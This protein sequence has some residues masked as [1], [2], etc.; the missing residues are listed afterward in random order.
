MK[1]VYNFNAGPSALPLQVL[2]EGQREFLDYKNTGMSIVEMS[3]RSAAYQELHDDTKE[4]LRRL[5]RIPE[6]YAVLFLQGGGSTQFFMTAANFFTKSRAAYVNTGV[7]A[8]K[9]RKEAAFFGEAYEAA[10]SADCNHSY[11]PQ[12]V[13]LLP[14]TSYLHITSNNT[15]YGTQ[16]QHFPKVDIPLICDMSSDILSK[17]VEVKDFSFIY[18]GAQKNLAP[19]GVVLGIGKKAF[20]EQARKELPTMVR[21]QT[22]MDHD[23]L[24]NTPPVF[25]IYMMNKTLHWIEQMGGVEAMAERNKKKADSLY[26]VID[27]SKGFYIGHA[28]REARSTMNVTFRLKTKNQELDFIEKAKA[29]GFVGVN[30][31][32]LVG[33]CRV[34]LYNAVE[35]NACTAFADFMKKYEKENR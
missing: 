15:I 34:S 6:E 22:F 35:P 32:R 9:A 14:D 27:E 25:C 13:T 8:D 31:H 19:A 28:K 7:W 16:Y 21:Y 26:S 4:T 24:Y 17:P 2:E 29:A 23:S 18:A 10:S 1:R 11:I 33:G 3:H 12:E 5:L 30:G 20:I